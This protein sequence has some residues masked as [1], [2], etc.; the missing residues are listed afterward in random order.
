M[1]SF[2]HFS[3]SDS[4]YVLSVPILHILSTFI[5]P[6]MIISLF[7]SSYLKLFK[8]SEARGNIVFGE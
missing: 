3:V 4:L 6:K 2:S 7:T 8:V 5:L 1:S